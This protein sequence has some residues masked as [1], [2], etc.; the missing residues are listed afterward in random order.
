ME[1][2]A[3]EERITLVGVIWVA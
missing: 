2:L 3:G 1:V